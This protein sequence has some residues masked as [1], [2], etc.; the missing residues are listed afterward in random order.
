M[1][2]RN[3]FDDF[4]VEEL[5]DIDF[6]LEGKANRCTAKQRQYIYSMLDEIGMTQREAVIE[7]GKGF[8][9]DEFDSPIKEI[10]L[11]E[12]SELIE[13]LKPLFYE[14]KNGNRFGG[15]YTKPTNNKNNSHLGGWF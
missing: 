12:A 11:D 3:N 1:S 4:P 10:S 7:I 2:E 14:A 8:L 15:G 6:I 9:A 5:D 13:Y